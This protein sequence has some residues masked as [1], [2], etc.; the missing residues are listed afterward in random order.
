[1]NIITRLCAIYFEIEFVW[2][3]STLRLEPHF[4]HGRQA[5]TRY[6]LSVIKNKLSFVDKT[7]SNLELD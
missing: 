7:D 1:M 5:R 2:F 6:R 3:V 4:Y